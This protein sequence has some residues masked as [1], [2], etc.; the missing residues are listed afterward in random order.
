[1]GCIL[2]ELWTG[3][4]LFPN[5][6]IQTLLAKVVSIVGEVP[7]HVLSAAR[8]SSRYF[9]KSKQVFERREGNPEP[10]I[11]KTKKSSLKERLQ[12]EDDSFVD[13]VSKLLTLDQSL[14]PSAKEAL[15]HSFLTQDSQ[16]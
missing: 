3:K 13:F 12:C 10:V 9:T 14:R 6:S 16:S 2:A 15:Q 1:M 11:I 7:D 8:Y 4:V 5:D